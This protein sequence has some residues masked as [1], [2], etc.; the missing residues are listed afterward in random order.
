MEGAP[1]GTEMTTDSR[2]TLR[3]PIRASPLATVR[4]IAMVAVCVALVAAFLADV[5]RSTP[6]APFE[7]FDHA[8]DVRRTA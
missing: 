3:L 7:A 1:G 5:W 2:P 4:D 6:P 8:A